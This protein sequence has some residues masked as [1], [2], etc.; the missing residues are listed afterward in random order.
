MSP[1][2]LCFPNTL[3]TL[4]GNANGCPL[5]TFSKLN[6]SCFQ[7]D[8]YADYVWTPPIRPCTRSD[9]ETSSHAF[10]YL[11]ICSTAAPNLTDDVP[12]GSSSDRRSGI[13]MEGFADKSLKGFDQMVGLG[14]RNV[15]SSECT[16]TKFSQ[17]SA[18][19]NCKF[20]SLQMYTLAKTCPLRSLSS[21]AIEN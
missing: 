12:A 5:V 17:W 7:T 21:F 9:T 6:S 20:W 10:R 16:S 13:N 19:L 18:L 4:N 11:Q 1:I 8:L 14:I 3:T 2:A 15:P